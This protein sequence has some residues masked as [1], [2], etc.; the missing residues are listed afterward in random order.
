MNKHA[1][2]ENEQVEGF[3]KLTNLEFCVDMEKI[4]QPTQTQQLEET[5]QQI[6]TQQVSPKLIVNIPKMSIYNKRISS[7]AMG[8][9][10]QHISPKKMNIS[11]SPQ[12]V[13]LEEEEPREQVNLDMVESGTSTVEVEK[14]IKL[15]SEGISRTFSNKKNIFDKTYGASYQSK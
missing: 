8:T 9:S 14:E 6:Q 13:N 4:L 1:P 3:D 7:D 11:Q 10:D 5:L 12:I 2:Y 15:Q